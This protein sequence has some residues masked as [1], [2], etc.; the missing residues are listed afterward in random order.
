MELFFF[1]FFLFFLLYSFVYVC[2]GGAGR[3]GNDEVEMM[4][5]EVLWCHIAFKIIRQYF[6]N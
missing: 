4:M 2:G 1:M 5:M 3:E 6:W